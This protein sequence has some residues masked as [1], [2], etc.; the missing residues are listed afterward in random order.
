MKV[1]DI[2]RQKG[3]WSQE[4]KDVFLV[5]LFFYFCISIKSPVHDQNTG[6]DKEGLVD[7]I[8]RQ[9]FQSLTDGFVN[10]AKPIHADFFKHSLHAQS[11]SQHQ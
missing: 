10:N 3:L 9:S 7:K 2:N 5:S 6:K 1:F 4:R 11:I 8:T